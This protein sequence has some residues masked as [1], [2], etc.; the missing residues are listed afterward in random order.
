MLIWSNKDFCYSYE[1]YVAS[2]D[3]VCKI[4]YLKK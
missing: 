3:L 4:K 2:D 1:L